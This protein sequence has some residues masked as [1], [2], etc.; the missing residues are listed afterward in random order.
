MTADTRTRSV[1]DAFGFPGFLR[2]GGPRL[3][4]T[5]LVLVFPY[6]LLGLV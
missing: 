3:P 1:L 4:G 5:I 6:S 2:E